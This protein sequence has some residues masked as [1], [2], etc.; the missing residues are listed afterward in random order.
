[1]SQYTNSGIMNR[2]K[3][4]RSPKQPDHTGTSRI[5]CRN[6]GHE[7]EMEVAAWDRT[8]GEKTFT[9]MSYEHKAE[10][11][12]RKAEARARKSGLPVEGQPPAHAEPPTEPTEPTNNALP[13]EDVPF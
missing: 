3:W 1:M 2:N 10:A 12:A 7:N 9:T 5:T 6:C 13:G 4:K 8:K 11:E